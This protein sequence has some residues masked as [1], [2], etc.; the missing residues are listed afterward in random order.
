MQEWI[1]IQEASKR[2]KVGAAAVRLMLRDGRI[3]GKAKTS[4]GGWHWLV[5]VNSMGR[6]MLTH[7]LASGPRGVRW[8]RKVTAKR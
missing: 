8:I 1:T 7:R 4:E 2:L 5:H 6:F 3:R